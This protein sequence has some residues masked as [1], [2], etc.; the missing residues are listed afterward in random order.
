MGRYRKTRYTGVF[1][2]QSSHRRHKGRLDHAYYIIYPGPQRKRIWERVGWASQGCTAAY[3]QQVRAGRIAQRQNHS[4]DL[5]P[6][7]ALTFAQAWEIAW[8]RHLSSLRHARYTELGRYKMYLEPALGALPL[9]SITSLQIEDIRRQLVH[10]GLAPSTIKAVIGLAGKVYSLMSR[11]GL[12]QGLSPAKSIRVKVPDNKRHRFLSPEQTRGLL[13]ALA[14]VDDVTWQVSMLSLY[15]G[16]RAGEIM[17]LKG[18]DIDLILG[19]ARIKNTKTGQDRTVFL[20]KDLI[21]MLS[22]MDVSPGRPLFN[23]GKHA[24]RVSRIFAQVV[25]ALELNDG[26]A[27]RRDRIVF[28]SLRHT[29]AS[30]MVMQGKD[31][32]LV[33]TLLGHKSVQMTRRYAHLDPETQRAA[34]EAIEGYFGK[35]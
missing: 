24:R 32:Y 6:A 20:H 18:Q 9:D 30:L 5:N 34:L 21:E 13:T 17:A 11:W 2:Q 22:R 4:P 15:T 33:S 16:M 8:E 25:K 10:K 7:Q 12:Y 19:M 28:H 35:S 1:I 23:A 27:D 31:I 26:C 3:A 14:S 29:F